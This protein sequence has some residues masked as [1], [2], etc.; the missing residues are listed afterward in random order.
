MQA[1][2]TK[3]V[4]NPSDAPAPVG[5]YSHA[6]AVGNLLFCSGQIP[7][8]PA[9]GALVAG[10]V[11]VQTQRVLENIRAILK[12]E[13]LDLDAVVKTTVYLADMSDFGAMNE[14]YSKYFESAPPARSTVAVSGLPRG[15]RVE[16]EAVA[17]R[18]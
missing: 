9:T 18:S 5:P 17:C 14:V 1:M 6:V 13:N 10:D 3:K 16:I 15:A 8:D 12:A 4:V 7:I 11:R 2:H